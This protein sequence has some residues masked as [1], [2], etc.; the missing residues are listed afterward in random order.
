MGQPLTFETLKRIA[1]NDPTAQENLE[2]LKY[3]FRADI[4][5]ARNMYRIHTMDDLIDCL[6][7]HDALSEFNIEP[8][9]EIA[10]EYGGALAAV[11]TNYHVPKE[12]LPA[13]PYNQ[14]REIRLSH[15]CATRLH[16]S[17]GI[18]GFQSGLNVNA[19]NVNAASP[20]TNP[21]NNSRPR[22]ATFDQVPTKEKRAAIY[23][24]IAS[25]IGTD[26]R[27][28]GRELD[29]C[30]GEM[31]DVEIQYRDLKTRVYKLFQIFEEDDSIDPKK[32]V[33]IICEALEQ[34]RRKDLRRKVERIMSH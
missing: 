1:A 26:W 29:I 20:T 8:F 32:H 33:L 17:G 16:I 4:G 3:M 2:D 19:P 30:Q 27:C 5:S 9:R 6:E 7:R 14:Y 31:D 24:L 10:D 28:L 21:V 34:C 12:L 13:E 22:Q 15:E 11:I 25:E 18:N 23:K